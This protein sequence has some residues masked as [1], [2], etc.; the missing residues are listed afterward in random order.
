MVETGQ[1]DRSRDRPRQ[2]RNASK[3]EQTN[4]ASN[5]RARGD[6]TDSLARRLEQATHKTQAKTPKQTVTTEQGKQSTVV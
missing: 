3:K 4:A 2:Q 6:K 1:G 5:I